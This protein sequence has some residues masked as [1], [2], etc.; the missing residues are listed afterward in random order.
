MPAKK[1]TSKTAAKKTAKKSPAKKNTKPAKKATAKV[2][3]KAVK[4]SAAKA[5][6][7]T[8]SSAAKAPAKAGKFTPHA[9]K[10]KKGDKAPSFSGKDQN[11]NMVSMEQFKGKKIVLYFYP[12]DDTPGCTATACNLRD[13]YNALIKAG[14]AVVGVSAD[15]EKS[16]RKFAAKYNL[17][18]SLIADTDKSVIKAYDVWGKKQ[19]MGRIFDGLIRTT[20]VID[21]KGVIAE[22]IEKVDTANHTQQI[23]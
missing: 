10:L 5:P 6:A 14:Y 12:K 20:F 23:L 7:K 13:N 3:K 21:E 4:K 16:H 15:D 9:T 19:F 22:V 1:S 17:P 11:G 2:A 18:F 8:N